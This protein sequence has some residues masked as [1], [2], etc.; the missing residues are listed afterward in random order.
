MHKSACLVHVLP[1]VQMNEHSTVG[2]SSKVLQSE[3]KR[4]FKKY[5]NPCNESYEHL[6]LLGTALETLPES[7]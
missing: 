3:L 5:T 1:F 4:R 2:V 6:F 7:N